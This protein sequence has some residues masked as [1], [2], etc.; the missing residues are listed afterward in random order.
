MP[1]RHQSKR[2]EKGYTTDRPGG[3]R[4]QTCACVCAYAH[5]HHSLTLSHAHIHPRAHAH[6]SKE[7][8][9]AT[10]EGIKA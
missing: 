4:G 3:Q 2:R 7:A 6:T 5:V 1:G 10:L 9:G 8:N